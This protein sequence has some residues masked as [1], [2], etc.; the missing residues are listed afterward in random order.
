[1]IAK[2][3]LGSCEEWNPPNASPTQGRPR[4]QHLLSTHSLSAWSGLSMHQ[5]LYIHHLI[6]KTML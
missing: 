1:M 2:A 6:L 5:V 4:N 3:T